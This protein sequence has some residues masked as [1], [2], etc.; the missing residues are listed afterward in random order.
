VTAADAR[1]L[2]PRHPRS[3]VVLGPLTITEDM[4]RVW[5]SDPGL[6]TGWTA[7]RESGLSS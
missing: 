6:G 7:W 1:F 4:A 5:L 3:A 2:L